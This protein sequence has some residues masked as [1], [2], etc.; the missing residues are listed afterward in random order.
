MSK[1][2]RQI[3]AV[4]GVLAVLLSVHFGLT[5]QIVEPGAGYDSPVHYTNWGKV[6]L[7]LVFGIGGVGALLALLRDRT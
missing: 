7:S 3:T 1:G 2:T 5:S 6:A 4:V